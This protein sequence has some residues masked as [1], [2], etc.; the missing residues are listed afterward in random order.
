V[1]PLSEVDYVDQAPEPVEP[2]APAP[3]ADSERR[4]PLAGSFH[5]LDESDLLSENDAEP[6]LAA[7]A[8][9]PESPAAAPAPARPAAIAVDLHHADQASPAGQDLESHDEFEGLI[10]DSTAE[11]L[12]A[13]PRLSEAPPV[14]GLADDEAAFLEELLSTSEPPDSPA[15]STNGEAVSPDDLGHHTRRAV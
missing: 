15:K 8:V 4:T 1:E 13:P 9:E 12:D 10:L 3:D 11:P 2:A 14:N 6:P 7:T 5:P